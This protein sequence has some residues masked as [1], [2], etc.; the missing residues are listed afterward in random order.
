MSKTVVIYHKNCSDGFAAAL[1]AWLAY[2]EKAE[3]IAS[4]HGDKAPDVAG[5]NVVI[6]DFSYPRQTL[7][8]LKAEANNLIVLDHHE[9]A[10]DDLAGLD[11]CH[12]DMTK[13]GAV[14]A[15]EWFFPH[16]ELPDL[17]AYVQDRDLWRWQLPMSKEVSAAIRSYPMDFAVWEGW[18]ISGSM[19][20]LAF[21]GKGI[22]RAQ[23]AHTDKVLA[24]EIGK[25]EIE[26]Y[27]VPIINTTTLL[28]EIV[29][30]LAK[31]QPFAAGYFDLHDRRV[32]SLRSSKDGGINVANIAKVFKGGGHPNAAG[33]WLPRDVS[34]SLSEV[35]K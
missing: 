11:F 30:E 20:K 7:L 17:F 24:G 28:S 25:V 29:G 6:L 1:A 8:D 19:E 13:S 34:F 10:K 27:E 32:F 4:Y 2:N 14:L 15:W 21:E 18:L 33:F 22:L 23:Q 35:E 3:F 12:F 31:G 26:G 16:K 5:K 9:S